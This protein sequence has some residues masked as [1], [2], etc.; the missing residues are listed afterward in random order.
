[1]SRLLTVS[2]TP[3]VLV[4]TGAAVRRAR[5]L[6]IQSIRS[7]VS[8]GVDR[9]LALSAAVVWLAASV[10]GGD[11]KKST[12]PDSPAEHLRQLRKQDEEIEA[13]FRKELRAAQT[14]EANG[15]ADNKYREA[16]RAWGNEALAA[17][18]KSADLPE[19]FE[20][21]VAILR[22]SGADTAEMTDLLRKHHAARPDL[23]K[24]FHDM[25]QESNDGRKFVEE[26]A[27]KSPVATVRGQAAL[28]L[29]W[30][31]KWRIMQDGEERF[32]FGTKLTEDERRRM[33]ARSEKYLKMALKYTEAPLTHGKGTVASSA[34][35]EL[36]GL[37]NLSHLRVGKVCPDIAG[38]A[39][40][41]TRFKLSDSRGKVTVVVF[42]ATWCAPCMRMVPHEKTLVERL[43][44]RP[45]AL[46]GV[47]G[48]DDR[49]RA[50][51][52][53][54]KAGM[55]W[56]SFWDAAERPE[57][58]I[59]KAWNVHAWPTVYVLDAKGVIRWIGRDDTKLDELVDE[60]IA[61]IEKK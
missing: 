32:G 56:P 40:E 5:R 42:W 26:M 57:G 53:A 30:Q 3:A 60:L 39:V 21:I 2:L 23:G 27:E 10:A 29:G 9:M 61:E 6:R 51:A 59:T 35:A 33:E 34:R 20:V 50:S 28:A 12:P 45:F 25:V 55:S 22:H 46:V 43:K 24:L 11:D 31:A 54:K 38:E 18:R 17:V 37:K 1:M 8:P 4:T 15:L 49:E 19:A 41:G 14:P 48:D 58:P 16:R 47:N 52:A 13:T 7:H 36:A 44:D